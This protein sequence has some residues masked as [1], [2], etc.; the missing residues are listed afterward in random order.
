MKKR[1]ARNGYGKYHQRAV[2][3]GAA[4]MAAGM[5]KMAEYELSKLAKPNPIGGPRMPA[6][7]RGH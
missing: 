7:V 2:Q 6:N 4:A 1:T 3:R 5:D